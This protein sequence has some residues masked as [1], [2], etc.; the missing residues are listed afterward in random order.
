MTE[1]KDREETRS[2]QTPNDFD[3]VL[4]SENTHQ[5]LLE[6][7]SRLQQADFIGLVDKDGKVV[8]TTQ[9]WPAPRIDTFN[10]G[11]FQHFKNNDDKGIYISKSRVSRL[12]P[13]EGTRIVLFS[14][15][16]NG[17]NN[18]FLGEVLVGVKLAYFEQ[19]Y[20]SIAALPGQTFVLLHRDGTVIVRYP[21]P[22][23]RGGEKLP[24]ESP[25]FR[26]V[27]Q[28]GGTFRTSGYF[29]GEAHLM[30]VH[31]LGD[32]PLVVNVGITETT[33]LATWRNE[34]A[35]LGIGT[36]LVIFCSGLLLKALRKTIP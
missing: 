26:L 23:F 35:V 3:R 27:S 16:I 19:I 10:S 34:A 31:P 6:R 14:K 7:L 24:A 8:N 5:F 2:A 32:Y 29:D 28:G 15:R 25:W 4:G 30:A 17:A 18:T 13:I 21:D 1:I 33:A 36:L 9:R 12:D 20:K 22:V 11:H